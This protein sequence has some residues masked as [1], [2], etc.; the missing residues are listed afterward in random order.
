MGRSHE[1]SL[2]RSSNS[3]RTFFSILYDFVGLQS[4]TLTVC[5]MVLE[6][7]VVNISGIIF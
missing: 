7:Y 3:I 2:L 6:N 5:W 4:F 1:I